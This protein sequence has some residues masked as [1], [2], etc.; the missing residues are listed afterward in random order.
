MLQRNPLSR[1]N[2][3]GQEE[4]YEEIHMTPGEELALRD[5]EDDVETT[6]EEL[7]DDLSDDDLNDLNEYLKD[8]LGDEDPVE[9][10]GISLVEE[11]DTLTRDGGLHRLDIDLDTLEA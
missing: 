5:V 7:L 3:P 9:D 11:L 2:R 1:G 8:L 6:T 10:E 4:K